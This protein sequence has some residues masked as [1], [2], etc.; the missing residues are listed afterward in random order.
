LRLFASPRDLTVIVAACLASEATGTVA[1]FALALRLS[2][3]GSGWAVASMW[4]AGTVPAVVLAPGIGLVLD[5]LE[6]L[7]L[8]RNLAL[9]AAVLDLGLALAPGVFPLLILAALLG[10]AGAA[11]APGLFAI[12]GPLAAGSE[13]GKV[14]ALTRLQAAQWTGATSGRSWERDW[15]WHGEP[16]LLSSWMPRCSPRPRVGWDWCG[17][18]ASRRPGRQTKAGL[19]ALRLAGAGISPGLGAGAPRLLGRRIR[20]WIRDEFG[21]YPGPVDGRSRYPRP[22]LRGILRRRQHGTAGVFGHG[23]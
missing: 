21:S 6:T 7:R 17:P 1:F 19:A 10:V 5:R 20:Q 8:L 4:L 12:A 11:S 2:Y 9:L 13:I 16:G 23:Q 15:W 3:T 14:G 18:D 22:S